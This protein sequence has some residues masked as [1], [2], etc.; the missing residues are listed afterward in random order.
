[1]TNMS[2]DRPDLAS[3]RQSLAFLSAA[4]FR[5]LALWLAALHLGLLQGADSAVGRTLMLVHLGLFLIW[6]PVVRGAYRLGWREVAIMLVAILVFI[7]ALSWGLIAAWVMVLAGIVG[8][9]AF[10][11]ETP[12]ARLPYQLAVAYLT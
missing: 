1:M 7:A 11:A 8:G 5:L 4:P 9:E 12:R 10:V 6:Q 2:C 3:A